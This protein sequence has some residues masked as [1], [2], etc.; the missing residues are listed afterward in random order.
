MNI[1]IKLLA[2][3][4]LVATAAY[5]ATA[6]PAADSATAPD[7]V[8]KVK[9]I[10]V[11]DSLVPLIQDVMR[12]KSEIVRRP[13]TSNLTVIDGDT[14]NE[15]LHTRNFGR[16]DRDLFNYI[17]IPKGQWEFGLTVSYGEFATKDLQMLDLLSDFDF[18]GHT[19]SVKPYLSYFIKNNQSLGL[20]LSYTES[21]GTLASMSVDFDDD[22][23]FD[24]KDAMYRNSSYSAAIMYRSYIGLARRG[25]FGV[26]NEVALSFA[27][28]EA[29][30]NRLIGGEPR[31]THTTYMESRLS[32]S[33]GICCLIMKNVS[34]NVSFGVVGFYL[35]NEKQWINNESAGN[36][37]SS[38]A[39]FRFNLFNI[40]LGLGIHI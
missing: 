31:K 21:K 33:P 24:I 13:Y 26:F 17:F 39:N 23:N 14:V 6:A 11:P 15:K 3:L 22:M 35:R 20:M 16:F 12:G 4:L 25:R 32:F 5:T 36:R 1:V 10:A 40:N 37:F 2:S 19:F 34:F 18:T 29:D 30:F 27:S 7:S 8:L 28:G 38:G 9:Y